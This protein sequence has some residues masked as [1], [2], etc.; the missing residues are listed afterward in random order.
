M[1][2]RPPCSAEEP[3][4][5]GAR[6][7]CWVARGTRLR[8]TLAVVPAAAV[9]AAALATS[10]AGAAEPHTCSGTISSTVAYQALVVPRGAN[11]DIR[12]GADVKVSDSVDIQAGATLIIRGGPD[13]RGKLTVGRDISVGERGSLK[14]GGTLSVAGNVSARG[15]KD[16]MIYDQTR[17]RGN[18][19]ISGWKHFIELAGITVDGTL[20]IEHADTAGLEPGAMAVINTSPGELVI[21]DNRAV[22]GVSID[23][24]RIARRLE[25]NH[26]NSFLFT[27]ERNTVAG[28]PVNERA[29]PV[30]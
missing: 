2:Q 25:C 17:I 27:F 24:N 23:D 10:A 12:P 20:S 18:F 8:L 1:M 21:N 19:E 22:T 14:A 13:R 29:C 5:Y 16:L 26:D 7:R 15:S 11:C 3:S 28:K 6:L 30:R 4:A 9:A